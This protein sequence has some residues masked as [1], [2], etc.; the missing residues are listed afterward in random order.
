MSKF[1]A[2]NV[3]LLV[4]MLLSSASQ[5][6]VKELVDQAQPFHFSLDWIRSFLTPAT[7]MRGTIAVVMM[8]TGFVCWLACLTKLNLSYAYP[9]ACTSV[10]L[11]TFLSVLFLD[12]VITL[13]IWAG[14][15]LIVLGIA[16]LIPRA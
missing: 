9:I 12:E 11:V 2:G 10:F 16:L 1:M 7:L 14:T 13:R 3:Y 5:I 15:A 4:F 6:L 8:G